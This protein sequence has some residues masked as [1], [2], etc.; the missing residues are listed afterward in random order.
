MQLRTRRDILKS[1][2][3]IWKSVKKL[4]EGHKKNRRLHY[5]RVSTIKKPPKG[6]KKIRVFVYYTF[7]TVYLS[8][9]SLTSKEEPRIGKQN[10]FTT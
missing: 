4:S 3:L 10:E 5:Y 2:T 8:F 9:K 7:L 6:Q 1:E